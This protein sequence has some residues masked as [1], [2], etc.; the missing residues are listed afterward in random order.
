[1]KKALL[2]FCVLLAS[3]VVCAQESIPLFDDLPAFQEKVAK[4]IDI[5]KNMAPQI[6][7]K[8]VEKKAETPSV[9]SATPASNAPQKTLKN[10]RLG[11]DAA[12]LTSLVIAPFPNLTVDLNDEK[13]RTQADSAVKKFEESSVAQDEIIKRQAPL[14]MTEKAASPDD[15]LQQLIDKRAGGKTKDGKSI[16]G[17]GQRHD[18]TGF[19][20]ADIGFN[21]TPEE[22]EDILDE[23]GYKLTKIEKS[24]PLLRTTFYNNECRTK[25]KLAV[26]KD[27]NKCV[28]SY[29][30]DDDMHYIRSETFVRDATRETIQ[31]VYTSPVTD[32]VSYKIAYENKGDSSLNSSRKNMAKKIARKNDFWNLIFDTYGLPDDS[33]KLVWGNPNTAYMQVAMYG[34]AYNAYIV[35]ENYTTQDEDYKNAIAEAKEELP[36]KATFTFAGDANDE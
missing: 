14:T 29:A 23:Q 27:V 8:S 31:V 13:A 28:L 35:M 17:F 34:S 3:K 9:N 24:I 16:N 2:C 7:A 26:L 1:M 5:N 11:R 25:K 21:M 10:P 32:N 18:I 19:L 6:T 15:Y 20:V 12:P 30:K 4:P 36:R 22:V 33:D